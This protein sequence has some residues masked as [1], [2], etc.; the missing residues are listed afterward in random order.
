MKKIT[1]SI[2]FFILA[3]CTY[4]QEDSLV[5]DIKHRSK[6]LGHNGN[7]EI[8]VN[9]PFLILGASEISY[10]RLISCYRRKAIL[11]RLINVHFS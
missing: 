9:I 3:M 4:A 1:L 10:E 5:N 2:A 8:K 6:A 7:H 11:G